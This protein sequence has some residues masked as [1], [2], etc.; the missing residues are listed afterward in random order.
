MEELLFLH[1]IMGLNAPKKKKRKIL[2]EREE[3]KMAFT[4]SQLDTVKKSEE[5]VWRDIYAEG[6]KTGIQILQLGPDSKVYKQNSM[7]IRKYVKKQ[8][9][10]KAEINQDEMDEK[11]YQLLAA[12]TADWRY[13]KDDGTIIEHA[14][15]MDEKGTL[16]EYNNENAVTLYS[17]WSFIADQMTEYLVDKSSFLAI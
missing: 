14:L 1:F 4:L 13:V 7:A 12:V 15:L 10:K 8:Q 3:E 11:S 17:S 16:F 9:D 6:V 2:K 5:G